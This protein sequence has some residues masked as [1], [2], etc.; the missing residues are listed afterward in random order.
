MECTFYIDRPANR[1]YWFS[2]PCNAFSQFGFDSRKGISFIS[3]SKYSYVSKDFLRQTTQMSIHKQQTISIE[4]RLVSLNIIK[5]K[6][7]A[8]YIWNVNKIIP[9]IKLI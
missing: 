6:H 8:T 3:N 5:F 1:V 9:L 7:G 4:V 2:K